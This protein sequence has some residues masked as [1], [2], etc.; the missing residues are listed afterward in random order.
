ML[1]RAVNNLSNVVAL[2]YPDINADDSLQR[3]K[4][5]QMGF[6]VDDY[7]MRALRY[8]KNVRG[9][10]LALG[11]VVIKV[12]DVTVAS[13]TSGTVSS[14]TKTSGFTANAH[15]G[16]VLIYETASVAGA[17][18]EGESA[19]IVSNDANT[20]QLDANYPLSAAP[21]ATSSIRIWGPWHADIAGAAALAENVLGCVVGA[22]GI[23]NGNFGWVQYDGV[24]PLTKIDP[25]AAI[26]AGALVI[27]GA[28][29]VVTIG[30]AA[31]NKV[32]G[33]SLAAAAV[34]TNAG[35]YP[36]MWTLGAR[37]GVAL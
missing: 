13:I 9:S 30:V 20:L 10:A 25:A 1:T 28:G 18:P 8:V 11:D 19:I 37:G 17:A 34:T 4:L 36:I 7:G 3:F 22:N 23:S 15:I 35:K 29:I 32:V 33:Y 26:A 5:G 6:F 24:H 16:K 31:A 2:G 21:V 14:I 27:T 12:A